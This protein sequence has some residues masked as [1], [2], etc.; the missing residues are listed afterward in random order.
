[1]SL[2]KDSAVIGQKNL[3]FNLEYGEVHVL[4][5]WTVG[6]DLRRQFWRLCKA[7]PMNE[8][9]LGYQI[10][11]FACLAYG[12]QLSLFKRSLGSGENNRRA[13]K[14]KEAPPSLFKIFLLLVCFHLEQQAL[15]PQVWWWENSK[16]QVLEGQA[17]RQSSALDAEGPE[18]TCTLVALAAD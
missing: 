1:M 16:G 7:K 6:L 5:T 9:T 11:T 8:M 10:L 4:E 15:Q 18:Q 14:A 13:R 12:L 2:L 17:S 3:F